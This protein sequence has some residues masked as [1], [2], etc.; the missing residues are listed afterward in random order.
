LCTSHTSAPPR[1]KLNVA[2]SNHSTTT[3]EANARA[4]HS[5][6][7]ARAHTHIHTHTHTHTHTNTHTHTHTHTQTHKTHEH[8]TTTTT[9]AQTESTAHSYFYIASSYRVCVHSKTHHTSRSLLTLPRHC[10]RFAVMHLPHCFI[11]FAHFL[12]SSPRHV[13]RRR[14]GDPDEA[15]RRE[16]RPAHLMGRVQGCVSEPDQRVGHRELRLQRSYLVCCAVS[17]QGSRGECV[18]AR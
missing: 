15:G 8:T 13:T 4:H 7:H 10:L 6:T 12:C 17:R 11:S 5:C 14:C 18:R 2:Q 9:T 16:R 1:S 3:A